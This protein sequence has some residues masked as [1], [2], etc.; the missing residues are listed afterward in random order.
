MSESVYERE[1]GREGGWV[2]MVASLALECIRESARAR[3]S[4]RARARERE[5]A[6][7]PSR[8]RE[9]VVIVVQKWC[10]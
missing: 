9:R 7:A 2:D 10:E 8:E 4:E 1:G 5:R 3:E 6:K